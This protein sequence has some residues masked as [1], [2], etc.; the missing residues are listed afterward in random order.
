NAALGVGLA[1]FVH[2]AL[3]GVEQVGLDDVAG[4]ADLLVG[5]LFAV[6][7]VAQGVTSAP[8]GVDLPILDGLLRYVRYRRQIGLDAAHGGL[9]L[10]FDF[11]AATPGQRRGDN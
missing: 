7:P 4:N 8:N 9:R 3:G 2:G 5:D 1:A 11:F 10:V 6:H